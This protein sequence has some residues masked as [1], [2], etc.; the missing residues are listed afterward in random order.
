MCKMFVLIN[1]LHYT[2]LCQAFSTFLFLSLE[3][4]KPFPETELENVLT[5]KK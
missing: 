5:K 2:Q 4:S 1:V 3:T